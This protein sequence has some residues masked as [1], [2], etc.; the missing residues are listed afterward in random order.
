MKN[1]RFY[2]AAIAACVGI[3][4]LGSCSKEDTAYQGNQDDMSKLRVM[5]RTDGE[6]TTPKEGKIYIFNQKGT[7]TDTINPSTLKNNTPIKI[8]PGNIKLIAIGSNDLTA[9]NL[10]YQSTVNDSSIIKLN[11]GRALTD[12]ILGTTTTTLE[13]GITTQTDITMNR[14]VICIKHITADNIPE[15]IIGTEIMIGPMYKNIK[16]NGKYT[17]DVDT[18][19]LALTKDSDG[20][21]GADN[22]KWSYTGDSIFSLPS[23]DNPSVILRLKTSGTTKEYTYQANKPLTKNH[24]VKLDIDFREGIK[25]YMTASLSDPVWEG[26]DSI[27]Y[28][29]QKE[30]ITKE[31][32]VT[33]P[34]A[35]GR[36]NKYY[37][38]SVDASKRT[39]VL[40]RRQGVKGVTNDSILNALS[41]SI[42]RPEWAIGGWRLP[43]INECRSILNNAEIEDGRLNDTIYKVYVGTYY[44]TNGDKLAT[45]TLK[46]DNKQRELVE[47]A[48]SGYSADFYFRPVIE[49]SY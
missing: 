45:I 30:D 16:L 43:T 34:V 1:N 29:F 11:S 15:D 42:N 20:L 35:G 27:K 39:A 37:V 24:F 6:P 12:L 41:N 22:G 32:A 40:L 18:I 26:T 13:E 8:K 2:Y 23:K 44:C 36:Y 21:K 33:H 46:G 31:V 10:P 4:S 5:T 25:T 17:N 38:V 7:C 47:N 48:D 3:V 49:I 14:E 28:Q 9:Y 19:R